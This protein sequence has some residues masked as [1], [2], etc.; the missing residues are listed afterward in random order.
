MLVASRGVDLVKLIHSET[1]IGKFVQ[2]DR[3]KPTPVLRVHSLY[4]TVDKSSCPGMSWKD[5]VQQHSKCAHGQ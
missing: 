2:M 3:L 5:H 1:L 4:S